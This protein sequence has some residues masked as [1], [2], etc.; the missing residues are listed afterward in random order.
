L[1]IVGDGPE[2]STLSSN[3]ATFVGWKRGRELAAMY[4]AMHFLLLP[5]ESDTLGL[6]LLEAAACGTPAVALRGTVAADCIGRYGS[7]VVV[8]AFSEG[9]FGELRALVRSEHFSNMSVQARAMAADHDIRR[10]TSTLL[11]AWSGAAAQAPGPVL[12]APT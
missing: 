7:G 2:R 4:K 10:G 12:I 9:L 3:S 6:V 8:D 5:A 1:V 11:R